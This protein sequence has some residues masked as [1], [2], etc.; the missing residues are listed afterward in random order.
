MT[1]WML[2]L[3]ALSLL[4]C[5]LLVKWQLGAKRSIRAGGHLAPVEVLPLKL[6]VMLLSAITNLIILENA[7]TENESLVSNF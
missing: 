2:I 1:W 3:Q 7:R 5:S 6:S 4:K